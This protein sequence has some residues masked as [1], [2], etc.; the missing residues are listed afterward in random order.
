MSTSASKSLNEA[1][2]VKPRNSSERQGKCMRGES[3]VLGTCVLKTQSAVLAH[4]KAHDMW[5][6]RTAMKCVK[7]DPKDRM[8]VIRESLRVHK[9]DGIVDRELSLFPEKFLTKFIETHK[10]SYMGKG[11]N[12]IAFVRLSY[13]GHYYDIGVG[14]LMKPFTLAIDTHIPESS[15]TPEWKSLGIWTGGFTPDGMPYFTKGNRVWVYDGE[16]K[17]IQTTP[18]IEKMAQDVSSMYIHKVYSGYAPKP[19][20]PKVIKAPKTQ[21]EVRKA[22]HAKHAQAKYDRL[23]STRSAATHAMMKKA[24]PTGPR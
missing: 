10:V 18:E 15:V 11:K 19:K 4:C 1:K 8:A 13:K 21:T 5:L 9:G 12:E 14:G 2:R 23:V 22:T 17:A 20:T 6:N 3:R 7:P 24:L 16:V